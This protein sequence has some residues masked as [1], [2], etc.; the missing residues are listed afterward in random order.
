[1]PSTVM[2]DDCF[3][4]LSWAEQWAL[5]SHVSFSLYKIPLMHGPILGAVYH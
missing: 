2:T 1:M 4:P 3:F 5:Y